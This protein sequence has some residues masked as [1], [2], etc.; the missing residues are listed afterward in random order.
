MNDQ[1][2]RLHS[3]IIQ[4]ECDGHWFLAEILRK[5]LNEITGSFK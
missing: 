2:K 4:L 1:V 5:Q 3:L